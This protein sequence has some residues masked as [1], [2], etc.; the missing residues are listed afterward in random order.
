MTITIARSAVAAFICAASF[1]LV[2]P[3]WADVIHMKTEL[4]PA[5]EVPP[6]SSNAHGEITVA[7]DTASKE[8]TWKGT[9]SGL[10]GPAIGAHFHRGD[11][12]KNGPVVIPIFNQSSATSPFAG[13]KTL[14]DAQAEDLLAGHWY[15]NVH[16]PTNKGG[17]IRGQLT[18]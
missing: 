4:T 14:T 2:T 13:S 12:G 7:Y 16:T 1:A 9:Y 8:L 10:T 5:N 6:N 18:K 17:E 11:R 3:S 15:V